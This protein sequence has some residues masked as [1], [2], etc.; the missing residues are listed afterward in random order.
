MLT[1][2]IPL[3]ISHM[4]FVFEPSLYKVTL[5]I[6]I[7]FSVELSI[8]SRMTEGSEASKGWT[9]CISLS[10]GIFTEGGFLRSFFRSS[11]HY[12]AWEE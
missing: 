7:I 3:E 8:D 9:L 6:F 12:G 5:L 10:F 1:L 4:P 11:C 2:T